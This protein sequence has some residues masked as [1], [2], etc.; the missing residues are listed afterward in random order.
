M[1]QYQVPVSMMRQRDGYKV[2]I[3]DCH[4]DI[5]SITKL[6]ILVCLGHSQ[7]GSIF[8][9]KLCTMSPQ[10]LNGGECLMMYFIRHQ[11]GNGTVTLTHILLFKEGNKAKAEVYGA[12]TGTLHVVGRSSRKRYNKS[13]W[14]KRSCRCRGWIYFSTYSNLKSNCR[15]WG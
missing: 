5:C 7:F 10:Y 14:N 8:L 15:F 2:R 6:W 11:L 3:A 9:A 4:N 1:N 13:Q 12:E